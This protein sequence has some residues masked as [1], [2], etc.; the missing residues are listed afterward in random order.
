MVAAML[1]MLMEATAPAQE[2][3][4]FTTLHNFDGTDGQGPGPLTQGTIGSFYGATSNGGTSSN[5]NGGCGTIF[6]V[7]PA[8]ALATLHSFCVLA[9]CPDGENPAAALIQASDG[10][11]YGTTYTGGSAGDGTIFRTTGTGALTTLYS[12][13]SQTGCEDGAKPLA[14]LVQAANGSFYGTTSN[15][16]VS[17]GGCG[18]SGCG[19]VFVI[20]SGGKLTTLHSFDG[21]D[22][23][24][25]SALVQAINGNFY[26][27]TYGGGAYGYGT[28]FEITPAGMLTTLYS[29]CAQTGCTDGENPQAPLVQAS[30]GNYYGTTSNGGA[31]S[32]ACG[33]V[34][35]GTAFIITS[36]GKLTTLHSFDGSDGQSPSG[37]V[38]GSDGNLYGITLFGGIN[39]DGTLFEITPGGTLTTLHSFVG[40]DGDIPSTLVQS[41]SGSFN[42]TTGRGG[43]SSACFGGCGTVFNLS[44][45]LS[46]FVET[47]PTSGKVGAA[48]RILGTN[49]TGAT[50]VTFDGTPAIF[51]V[52]SGSLISATVPTGATSGP[53]QVVTPTGTLTSNVN[54]RVLPQEGR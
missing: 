48:V 34:G 6:K 20:T 22:G 2:T 8:G 19:T 35:C 45:G 37:L 27:T 30:N 36:G 4:T 15:G 32:S 43:T 14:G 13:C 52:K 51:Q 39:G 29:F 40:S 41:T 54:F 5:C 42:G 17:N 25:P 53:V 50:S 47:R 3:V 38:Q 23:Q 11:F 21:S 31:N 44:V 46:P 7:T 49:L 10:N 26:G 28:V 33:G 9:G 16:G 12:F 24:F 18:A 1:M